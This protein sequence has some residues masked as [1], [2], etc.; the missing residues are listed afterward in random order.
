MSKTNVIYP[1]GAFVSIEQYNVTCPFCHT[2]IIPDYLCKDN[3]TLYARCPNQRCNKHFILT[4]NGGGF[5]IVEPNSVPMNKEFSDIINSIS[6]EFSKIYNQAFHAEQ[7]QLDHIC[8]VGYRKAL[9]FLIKDYLISK[10]TDENV[11]ENIK[12]KFLSN[13]IQENVQNENIKNVAKRALWLG[14][15]ETHYV[16][17]WEDKDVQYLK[18][19]IDLTVR[20]IENE[21]ETA[22]VL[23]EM[24]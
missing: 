4:S 14:N 20:W 19:L 23:Q 24:I 2:Q 15:D 3:N 12:K 16:R 22:Q 21:M 10:E 9:E 5:T 8:G 11:V 13:C 18:K 7:M 6:P 17:K 1:G